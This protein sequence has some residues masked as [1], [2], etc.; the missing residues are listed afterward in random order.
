MNS[1][2]LVNLLI[3]GLVEGA[4]IAL[5]ALALSLIMAIAR[6]PQ[7]AT[8]DQATLGAYVGVGAQT[9]VIAAG[10]TATLP[11]IALADRK[12]TRL[13]SSHRT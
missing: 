7:A 1:V 3:N 5:P 13:N 8:G 12:S 9:M 4:V 10:V 6:F 11:A 2:A